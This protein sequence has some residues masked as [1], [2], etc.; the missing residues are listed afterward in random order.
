[1]S[2]LLWIAVPGGLASADDVTLRVLVVPRLDAAVPL[3]AQG[4]GRWPP[5]ELIAPTTRASVELA[6]DPDGAVGE[7]LRV[8]VRLDAQDGLW[9]AFFSATPVTS[10]SAATERTVSVTPTTAQARRVEATY[11]GAAGALRNRDSLPEFEGEVAARISEY[12]QD[13]VPPPPPAPT[14]TTSDADFHRVLSLLREHP[15][16]LRALGLILELTIPV[17]ALP[18]TPTGVVR[19]GWPDAPLGVPRIRSPWS[20]F[21]RA[22]FLPAPADDSDLEAGMVALGRPQWELHTIDVDSALGR[23]RDAARSTGAAPASLPALRTGGVMLVRAEREV[24]LAAR[25]QAGRARAGRRDVELP[26]LG[27]DDLTLGYRVDVR[28]IGEDWH[29]LSVRDASYSVDGRTITDQFREEGHI[30][31]RAGLD[32]GDGVVRL[33]EVVARW[34]GWSLAVPRPAVDGRPRRGN[35]SSALPFDFVRDLVPEPGSLLKLRFGTT[36]QLRAR[37]AD[38]TGGGR[39]LVEPSPDGSDSPPIAFTRHEPIAAP[40]VTQRDGVLQPTFGPGAAMDVMVVREGPGDTDVEDRERVLHP[41]LA[42]HEVVER[43]GGFDGDPETTF[44]LLERGQLPDPAAAGLVVFLRPEPGGPAADLEPKVWSEDWPDF[45]PKRLRLEPRTGAQP[46][47]NWDN[48]HDLVVRLSPAEQASLEISSF[49]TLDRLGEFAVTGWLP[50]SPTNDQDAA[51]GAV[52]AVVSGR[53][54]MVTPARVVTVVHAVRKPLS[55]P[56]GTF[57]PGRAEGETFATLT[58]QPPRLDVDTASTVALSVSASW[59]EVDDR[60]EHPVAGVPLP[61]VPVARGAIGLPLVQHELGDTRHRRV[62]YSLTAVSRFRHFFTGG[63]DEDFQTS[64]ETGE[65]IVPSSARPVPAVVRSVVPAFVWTESRDGGVI[66]RR[67][68]GNRVRVELARPWFTTGA[69]EALAV[70]V[71]ES[72][73][74]PELWPYLT[75]VGRDPIWD[76]PLPPRFPRPDGGVSVAL[77]ET[78]ERV[79]A[80]PFGVWSAGGSWYADVV[81][82]ATASYSPMAQLAVGRFQR[83]SLEGLHLSAVSRTDFVPLLPDRTLTVDASQAGRVSVLL[84]GVEASGPNRNIVHVVPEQARDPSVASELVALDATDTTPAWV[85]FSG[86]GARLGE[87]VVLTI[88]TGGPLR[89]RIREVENVGGD[90]EPALGSADELQQR[91]VFT[92]VVALP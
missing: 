61:A 46:T 18:S 55:S 62:T 17:G 35:G 56:A 63:E 37:V 6:Q 60:G 20:A 27:A 7:P 31:A 34:D 47:L 73:P 51:Q 25:H 2:D 79:L 67:R 30:K 85:A 89:L 78:G 57:R 68:L 70:I 66:T 45:V 92:D 74:P 23:L 81:L 3:S 1:M 83:H 38:L 28:V 54:P 90:L 21:T 64:G 88:P 41:P 24:G 32:H 52:D 14:G 8:A 22:S 5:P 76:T 72:D 33:D 77:A 40:H 4:M 12:E 69:G 53:H 59:T 75:Q 87:P 11:R 82:P 26:T 9:D 39:L 49:L 13:A 50:R 19:V 16:V 65:V 42:A 84:E 58:P 10:P 36:Y 91:T 48:D 86:A 29:S 44:A 80:V 15:T 71:P 43:H